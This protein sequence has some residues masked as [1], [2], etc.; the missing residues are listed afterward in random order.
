MRQRPVLTPDP[1]KCF[2][3]VSLEHFTLW[4]TVMNSKMIQREGGKKK[5]WRR[6]NCANLKKK[7]K[8]K[9]QISVE[10]VRAGLQ[11]GPG[12][13]RRKRAGAEDMTLCLARLSSLIPQ[14]LVDI[15]K[16]QNEERGGGSEGGRESREGLVFSE[17]TEPP[18][19][20]ESSPRCVSGLQNIYRHKRIWVLR[21]CFFLFVHVR[22]DAT[23]CEPLRPISRPPPR[24][25]LSLQAV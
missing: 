4:S 8:K 15:S 23:G 13:D 10:E 14:S 21:F 6:K 12:S 5:A 7:K 22:R 17:P 16:I 3:I 18:P 24:P 11:S 20:L 1:L 25:P 2:P 9:K 19:P